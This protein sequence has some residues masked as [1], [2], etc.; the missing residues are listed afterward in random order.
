MLKLKNKLFLFSFFIILCFS[1]SAQGNARVNGYGDLRWGDSIEKVMR[2][3]PNLSMLPVQRSGIFESQLDGEYMQDYIF[4]NDDA[5]G[6][7]AYKQLVSGSDIKERLFYFFNN[8]LYGVTV[9]YNYGVD[10][11]GLLSELIKRYGTETYS[12]KGYTTSEL[13]NF[14]RN[15]NGIGWEI[16]G[17]RINAWKSTYYPSSRRHEDAKIIYL[18]LALYQETQDA[19][20]KYKL[21][22]YDSPE[23]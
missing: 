5:V 8:K 15:Y 14:W 17:T 12:P 1:C 21:N 23:L 7:C 11:N 10:E 20:E 16:T 22:D 19:K 9:Y 13:F 6:I 4:A 2:V 18:S 3:Y